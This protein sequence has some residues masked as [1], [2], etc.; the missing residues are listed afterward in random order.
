MSSPVEEPR[1][2]LR[3]SETLPTV[4]KHFRYSEQC[5]ISSLE[6][7]KKPPR[8]RP[9]EPSSSAKYALLRAYLS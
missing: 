9:F 2:S 8:P 5:S 6:E 1:F 7:P 4:K 3:A